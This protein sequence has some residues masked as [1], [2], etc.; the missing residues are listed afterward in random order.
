MPLTAFDLNGNRLGKGGGF[1]DKLLKNLPQT[2]TVGLAY[3]FQKVKKIFIE[4]WD[5]PIS[6]VITPSKIWIF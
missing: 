4:P 2:S 6:T 3:D 5:I 1:Y